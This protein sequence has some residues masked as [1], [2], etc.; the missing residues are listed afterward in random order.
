MH[1]WY[2]WTVPIVFSAFVTTGVNVQMKKRETLKSRMDALDD[3][4]DRTSV[5]LDRLTRFVVGTEAANGFPASSGLLG[6]ISSLEQKVDK[7]TELLTM[8]NK[9]TGGES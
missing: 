6:K 4:L 8:V 1:N 5:N 3:R 2:T 9:N 7:L